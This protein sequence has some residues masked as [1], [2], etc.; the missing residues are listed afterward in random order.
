[1]F[2]FFGSNFYNFEATRILGSTS[3]EG[4][5]V[6]EFTEAVSK[7]RQHDPESW[8]HA[9]HEQSQRAEAIAREAIRSGHVDAARKALLRASN[10]ARASGYMFPWA[11]NDD[12]IL[13]AAERSISLFREAIP[14]MDCR[15]MV[16]EIAYQ[17]GDEPPLP[18]YLYLPPPSRTM[19]GVGTQGTPVIVLCGGADATQEELYFAFVSAGLNLGYAVVTFD[20]PGQGMMLKKHKIVMR[21][22]FEAV[23]ARVLDHIQH[24]AAGNPNLRLDTDRMAVMGVSMGAYYALR[25]SLDPR[26]KACVSI[27]PFYGLWRLALTRMPTWYAKMWTSGWLPEQVFNASIHLQMRLH[28]PTRWEFQLGMAMMGTSTP[29][30]TLRRF[31]QFDL[32]AASDG[33]GSIVG[34]IRCPVMLTGASRSVYATADESTIAIYNGLS[35]VPDLLKEVWIPEEVGNGGLTGKVGAWGLL[36]QKSFQFLDKSLH[37]VREPSGGNCQISQASKETAPQC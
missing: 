12:R 4:C 23:T 31:Q 36:A 7:I 8:Y 21:P 22:N 13:Q 15:V 27:D 18:G 5:E 37:V 1:M 20:G 19:G 30:D 2:K 34:R 26:V 3:T 24:M 6:A 11:G 14:Y 29:G 28:F 32:D 17:E 33:K 16:L 9:W 25:S 35:Q 10:Y